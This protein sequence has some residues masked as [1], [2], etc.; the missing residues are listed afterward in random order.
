[1]VYPSSHLPY[2][3]RRTGN[4][5]SNNL[6]SPYNNKAE[7]ISPFH[8]IVSTIQQHQQEALGIIGLGNGVSPRNDEESLEDT[9]EREERYQALGKPLMFTREEKRA[10]VAAAAGSESFY[11]DDNGN[12]M[13]Y[14][15]LD[16]SADSEE[17]EREFEDE[18]CDDILG[19]HDDSGA[20]GASAVAVMGEIASENNPILEVTLSSYRDSV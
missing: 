20:A 14:D 9:L 18:A 4:M 16:D 6:K 15:D 17:E 5:K 10:A 2:F 11:V 1:M 8:D 13:E 3:I 7:N 19:T 12:R